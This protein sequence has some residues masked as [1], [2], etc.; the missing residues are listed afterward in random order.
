MPGVLFFPSVFLNQLYQEDQDSE[1][2][3]DVPDIA[4]LLRGRAQVRLGSDPVA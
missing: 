1:R 2:L 4:Q 3:G